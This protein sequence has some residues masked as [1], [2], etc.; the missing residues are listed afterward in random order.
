MWI[1]VEPRDPASAIPQLS[2]IKSSRRRNYYSTGNPRF[3]KSGAVGS[4]IKAWI[5]PAASRVLPIAKKRR[6]ERKGTYASWLLLVRFTPHFK[7]LFLFGVN[8]LQ[9]SSPPNR[10]LLALD[11]IPPFCLPFQF[12]FGRS[13]RHRLVDLS[14][15][16]N[17]K[18]NCKLHKK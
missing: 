18:T 2:P 8:P 5:E 16:E 15:Q 6:K 1:C 14:A 3:K 12:F 11:F 4:V 9:C 13:A 10:L 7:I 17:T